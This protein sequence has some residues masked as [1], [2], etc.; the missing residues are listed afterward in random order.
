MK[1][2]YKE[3]NQKGY[4]RWCDNN[5]LHNV[6]Y[7]EI[8]SLFDY[9][10]KDIPDKLRNFLDKW[11]NKIQKYKETYQEMYPV[12]LAHI[13]FIYQDTVYCIYPE[14]IK[15]TYKSNFLRDDYYDVSYDSLFETYQREL[16]SELEKDLGVIYSRY[17]G[18]LD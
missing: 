11:T 17:I 4:Y 2:V 13:E 12:K 6:W 8:I 15:A 14:T 9:E 7:K 1:V 5:G 10:E 18:F 3:P 16:R